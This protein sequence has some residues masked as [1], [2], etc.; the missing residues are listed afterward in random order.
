MKKKREEN[1]TNRKI[2]MFLGYHFE[3]GH[4]SWG[5]GWRYRGEWGGEWDERAFQGVQTVS[6]CGGV[7]C[8][9]FHLHHHW[10]LVLLASSSSSVA[11]PVMRKKARRRRK[12]L[13]RWLLHWHGALLL[14]TPATACEWFWRIQMNK[15]QLC[16][17]VCVN[18]AALLLVYGCYFSSS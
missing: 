5:R 16:V 4:G 12:Y 2:G 15:K 3:K 9:A 10:R 1:I 14:V 11:V 7:S 18:G 6:S 13:W 8:S 17:V